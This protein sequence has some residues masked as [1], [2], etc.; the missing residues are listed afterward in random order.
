MSALEKIDHLTHDLVVQGIQAISSTLIALF[1]LA[2]LFSLDAMSAALAA[3]LVAGLYLIALLAVRRRVADNAAVIGS[4]H[5]QR[6]KAVQENLAG[7][8]DIIIDRSQAAH[9]RMFKAIDR[10]FMK[11]RAEIAVL[12][13][14]PRFLVEAIGLMLIAAIALFVVAR[15]GG[16]PAAL[17]ILGALALGAQRLLPL[18]TQIYRGWVSLTS[19]RPMLGEVAE[20]LRLPVE[21]DGSDEA[22]PIPLTDSVLLEGVSFVYPGRDHPALQGVSLAI[23]RGA[24]VAI[25]GRTGSGKSTL[26]DLLMG[27]IEPS[28]GR[29]RVDGV[30]LT[31]ERMTGWR[32][33]IAHVPQAAFLADSSI[34]ANIALSAPGSQPDMERVRQAAEMAQL[35]QFIETL[36]EAYRTRVGERGIRLS[37]GQRQRLALARAIYKHASLLVLDEATSALDDLTEHAVLAALDGLHAEGFTIVIIAHRLSTVAR[38]D[39]I[40]VLDE[41]ML[42]QS[43]SYEELVSRLT[44]LHQEGEL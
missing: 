7:I 43:G 20:L 16:L 34:A 17:P 13:T 33:S 36:P 4:T 1:V 35:A 22:A 44:R 21:E 19:S 32:Q 2:I 27:L 26:A 6:I 29:I 37:G 9:L 12:S 3:L 11:A 10:Q 25:T 31:S 23:P 30:P 5:E 8:R 14:A 28:E 24:R 42:V 41:G 40:F 38:C 39:P 18:A 15:P